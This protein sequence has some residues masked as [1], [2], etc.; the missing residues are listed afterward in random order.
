M[1]SFKL[2]YNRTIWGGVHVCK[3]TYTH[4]KSKRNTHYTVNVSPGNLADCKKY[5][6]VIQHMTQTMRNDKNCSSSEQIIAQAPGKE[7]D[8][9]GNAQNLGCDTV[10]EVC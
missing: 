5:I 9:E 3:C 1:L 4:V 2:V 8:K 6:K 10:Q 7:V